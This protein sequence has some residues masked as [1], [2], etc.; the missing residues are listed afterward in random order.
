MSLDPDSS[1]NTLLQKD[2]TF[3]RIVKRLKP[4]MATLSPEDKALMT[5]MVADCYFQN[6]KSIQS[7]SEG[8]Y[9]MASLIMALLTEQN[10][11]IKE[12]EK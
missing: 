9:L 6:Q 1:C 2:E 11:R 10:K 12:V 4:M 3:G 7:N 8:D 5:K